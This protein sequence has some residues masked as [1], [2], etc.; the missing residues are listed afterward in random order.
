MLASDLDEMIEAACM[1]FDAHGSPQ[2]LMMSL[3]LE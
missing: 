2:L 3:K 1:I